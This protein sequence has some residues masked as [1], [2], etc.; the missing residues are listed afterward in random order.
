MNAIMDSFEVYK[1]YISLKL[2]FTTDKYDVIQQKGKVRVSKQVFAKRKDLYAI[3]KVAKTYSNKEVID[4]LIANFVSGDRW[5][6]I[7]NTEA[8][9]TYLAW[10]KRIE[11][12]TYIFE[13]DLDN[14]E[15]EL[16]TKE[17]KLDI[18][19]YCPKNEHP[20]IIKT[21]LRNSISI[22]TLVILDKIYEFS[23]K[24]DKEID[25]TIIWPELSRLIKK[26]QPFLLID[27]EKFNGICRRRIG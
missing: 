2:H 19:F 5:G 24:F 27:K 14:L 4:F 3:N 16:E 11:G 17:L 15:Q 21:Y 7:F 9:E 18:L 26:Y 1:H 23:H 25:D 13:T 8:R 6:G 10:K 12:L 20:Y 22:E